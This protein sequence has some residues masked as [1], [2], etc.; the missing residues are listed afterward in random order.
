MSV[1][2]CSRITPAQLSPHQRTN[3]QLLNPL[4]KSRP[5]N[6]LL[7]NRRPNQLLRKKP[8]PLMKRTELLNLLKRKKP[9]PPRKPTKVTPSQ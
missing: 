3:L 8:L 2:L 5:P 4:L 9:P 6:P 7:K 1:S